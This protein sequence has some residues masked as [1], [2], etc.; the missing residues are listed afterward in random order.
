ML[1]MEPKSSTEHELK[2]QT[3]KW[4][5]KLES[6]LRGIESTGRLPDNQYKSLKRN[7]LAYVKDSKHFMTKNDWVRAFE[8]VIY[9]WGIYETCLRT[10]IVKNGPGT[11]QEGAKKR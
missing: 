2:S 5:R 10:G 1:F 3:N 11:I 9:A 6:E 4:L 8:A 7:M